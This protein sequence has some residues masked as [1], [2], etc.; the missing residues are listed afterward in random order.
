MST[1]ER[2]VAG[3]END[4]STAQPPPTT[5]PLTENGPSAC[6]HIDYGS[7]HN[8]LPQDARVD[9]KAEKKGD[10]K[11]SRHGHHYGG[12][13][14]LFKRIVASTN[15]F[16][17]RHFPFGQSPETVGTPGHRPSAITRHRRLVSCVF[18]IIFALMAMAGAM[19]G[20]VA[21]GVA[22][23]RIVQGPTVAEIVIYSVVV[24]GIGCFCFYSMCIGLVAWLC[25]RKNGI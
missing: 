7:T 25:M 23:F 10:G 6:P 24:A 16:L 2:P 21:V 11:Q 4:K 1:H 14:K 22:I 17:A 12:I 15:A 3:N 13:Q 5:T 8:T 18:T 9:G 19:F 20:T